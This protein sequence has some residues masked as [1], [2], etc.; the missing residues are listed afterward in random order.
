MAKETGAD[1]FFERQGEV[2]IIVVKKKYRE[3][4][5]CVVPIYDENLKDFR[6]FP[7]GM[8]KNLQAV[9]KKHISNPDEQIFCEH[10]RVLDKSVDKD[11]ALLMLLLTQAPIIAKSQSEVNPGITIAY[12]HDKEFEANRVVNI[13]KTEFDAISKLVGMSME[14][15]SRLMYYL[16][17]N[18]NSMSVSVMT[19]TLYEKAQK[20]PKNIID[21]FT[22]PDSELLT[23]INMLKAERIITRKSNAFYYDKIY[24]GQT[25][26]EV[27]SSLK[28]DRNQEMLVA[29]R[30]MLR[31]PLLKQELLDK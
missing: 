29:M 14:N 12:L 28:D 26:A 13:K 25:N 31:N 30:K 6:C 15:M 17:E 21:Y 27:L 8:P 3:K 24:L 16:G 1:S 2:K 11:Y 4:P 19:A 23:L 22:D 9:V 18:P 5:F 20:F 7:D 10:N